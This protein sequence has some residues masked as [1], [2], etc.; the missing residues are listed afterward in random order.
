MGSTRSQTLIYA[1]QK[2]PSSYNQQCQPN[3]K[4]TTALV[5]TEKEGILTFTALMILNKKWY[6]TRVRKNKI[7]VDTIYLEGK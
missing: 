3:E 1:K 2:T 5:Y 6:D 4:S 7:Y